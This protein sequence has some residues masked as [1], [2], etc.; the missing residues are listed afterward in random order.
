MSAAALVSRGAQ[1][2]R[3][4]SEREDHQPLGL[5][6]ARGVQEGESASNLDEMKE[7]M[8]VSV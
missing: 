8:N 1:V 7:E 4:L 3:A 2:D 5:V 6:S